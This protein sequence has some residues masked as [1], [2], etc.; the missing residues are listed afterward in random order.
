MLNWQ[1]VK[2]TQWSL[3]LT[4]YKNAFSSGQ[5]MVSDRQSEQ[6]LAYHSTAMQ[7]S[8]HIFTGLVPYRL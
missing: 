7:H 3:K 4:L 1:D 8:L 5:K 6:V 2:F